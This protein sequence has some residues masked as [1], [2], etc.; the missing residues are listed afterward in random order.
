MTVAVAV[1]GGGSARGGGGEAAVDPLGRKAAADVS[2]RAHR[3]VKCGGGAV[4]S[5]A[6]LSGHSVTA[7]G[8][9]HQGRSPGPVAIQATVVA[10]E[11]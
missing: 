11:R 9:P 2:P 3:L 5:T 10:A 7:A 4:P 8:Q 6:D 1:A